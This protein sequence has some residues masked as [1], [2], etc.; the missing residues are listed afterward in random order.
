MKSHVM[1][2]GYDDYRKEVFGGDEN[3]VKNVRNALK[4]DCF[5][6]TDGII[7][8]RLHSDIARIHCEDMEFMMYGTSE[9]DKE[10]FRTYAFLNLLGSICHALD[11]RAK[12][13]KYAAYAETNWLEKSQSYYSKAAVLEMAWRSKK[14]GKTS[15]NIQQR[16]S[17]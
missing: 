2:Y 14:N 3:M 10:N 8:A 1:K 12:V 6:L 13:P 16:K 9:E 11:S 7:L 4:A 15:V 17:S 5:F